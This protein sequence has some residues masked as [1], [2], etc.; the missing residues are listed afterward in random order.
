LG[1]K[2]PLLDLKMLFGRAHGRC[3]APD[4]DR[5]LCTVIDGE[6]LGAGSVT[7]KIAHIRAHSP[8]GPRYDPD[9][10]D[11]DVDC[12]ANWILLC[13]DH[14]KPADDHPN[15]FTTSVLEAWKAAHE[16][17]CDEKWLKGAVEAEMPALEEVIQVVLGDPLSEPSD[18]SI[19]PTDEKIEKNTLSATYER[20]LRR[21]AL[22][23]EAVQAFFDFKAS[24][25]PSFAD[26]IIGGFRSRY[27]ELKGD[28]LSGDM[29][30][31]LLTQFA[32]GNSSDM[33]RQ[34][35]ANSV[36]TY[37]FQICEVFEK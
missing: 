5:Q 14:H 31:E 15:E 21:G 17:Q 2:Y 34:S 37:F 36:L 30:Y 1:R 13:E 20:R 24:R 25:D 33:D 19:I 18:Y 28:G 11:D 22:Q 7:G 9:L 27:L 23:A 8:L 35:A 6:E 3:S 16:A 4:C 12:Y 10:A 32:A 26:G 29:I